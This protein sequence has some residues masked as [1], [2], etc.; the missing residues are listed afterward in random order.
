MDKNL[1]AVEDTAH[2]K[3]NMLPIE[4]ILLTE[5]HEIRGL[6]YVSRNTKEERR[7]TDLLND[8]RRRFLAITDAELLHRHSPSAPR[9]YSFMQV[10]MDKII[11]L[12]PSTQRL[13]NK[14][15]YGVEDALRFDQFRAKLRGQEV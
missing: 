4:V 5:D 7:L 15:N 10:H 6:V 12:H 2:P 9:H 13:V 8:N 14:N 11:M 3:E 1:G